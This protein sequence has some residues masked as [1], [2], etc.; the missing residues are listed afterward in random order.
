MK[1]FE[2]GTHVS[3][4][5]PQLGRVPARVERVDDGRLTLALFVRPDT[6]VQWLESDE[7]EIEGAGERGMLRAHGTVT[8]E[9]QGR[10]SLVTLELSDAEVVQRRDFVRVDATMPVTVW[11][12]PD[13]AAIDTFATNVSG[14]G[15]ALAGPSILE[16]GRQIRFR[17]RLPGD[18]P[19]LE[20]TARVVR[21]G[22]RGSVGCAFEVID[23]H[24]RELIVRFTFDQQRLELKRGTT[25]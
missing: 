23:E 10:D 7:A 12:E 13:G 21:E 9:G 15:F 1:G 5:H 11:P 6:P 22:E 14:A 2:P 8:A 24:G 25:S 18:R 17:L 19:P 4:H 3:L 16:I 20:G